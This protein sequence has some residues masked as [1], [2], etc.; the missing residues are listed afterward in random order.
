MAHANYSTKQEILSTCD[1]ERASVS[2]T[3]ASP[4]PWPS[5][6]V[7]TTSSPVC[8]MES[9][10]DHENHTESSASKINMPSNRTTNTQMSTKQYHL[11]KKAPERNINKNDIDKNAE[12]EKLETS[13]NISGSSY[14]DTSSE[15]SLSSS[16]EEE[17]SVI[18][19]NKSSL[20]KIQTISKK[21]KAKNNHLKNYYCKNG[22]CKRKFRNKQMYENHLK[23]H[24]QGNFSCNFCPKEKSNLVL[25]CSHE[26]KLHGNPL[27]SK[28]TCWM[29]PRCPY[30]TG[31]LTD[32]EAHFA[33]THFGI[34][35]D[36]P[37]RRLLE[38]CKI[39]SRQ[40]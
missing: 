32:F 28:G 6:K 12:K 4:I 23:L 15:S 27:S 7:I 33:F 8:K 38:K 10:I 31:Y 39:C 40:V 5:E 14:S 21:Y 17:Y 9:V 24:S 11:R 19:S 20:T 30:K 37:R 36:P 35:I 16:S 29:C 2:S 34:G 25:L 26:H 18:N 13:S 3:P 22:T 1:L